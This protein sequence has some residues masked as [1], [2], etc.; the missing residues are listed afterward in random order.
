MARPPHAVVARHALAAAL[1]VMILV[2]VG[3]VARGLY[4]SIVRPR[5]GWVVRPRET[6]WTAA[7]GLGLAAGVAEAVFAYSGLR[8]HDCRDYAAAP[9]P[10]PGKVSGEKGV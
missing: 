4:V 5:A 8:E 9:R 3:S 10:V 7:L 2:L 1:I 6:P